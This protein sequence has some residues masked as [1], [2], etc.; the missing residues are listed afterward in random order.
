MLDRKTLLKNLSLGFL[1]LLIFIIADEIFGLTVGLLVAIAFGLAETIFVYLREKRID[2]FILF[3]TGL[4]VVLGLVSILLQNDLFFKLKPG[5][6]EIILIVLLGLTAF[7]KNPVL[8]RMTGRYMKGM[9]FSGEQIDQMRKMMRRMVYLFTAHTILIFYSAYYLS[10]EAWGFISGGLLYILMGGI[11]LVEFIRAR[12]Q[13]RKIIQQMQKE[14]WFDIVTPK[15]EIIGKAP[16]SAVHGNPDLLHP[17][18]HVHIVNSKGE[19]FLQKRAATKDLYPGYWDTAIGGHVSSGE[20]INHALNRE[21]EEELGISMVQFQPLFRYV[22][23]NPHESELVHGFLLRD[24]GP[25]YINREEISRGRFWKL[26]EIEKK[27]GN[28]VFT[29][30]FEHDFDLLKK[31]VFNSSPAPEKR[32]KSGR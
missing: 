3:D 24:D 28:N 8:I 21:A 16:R 2:R 5:L 13:R 15:G 26:N 1:P 27:L 23:K 4:I 10:T 29:P 17:V 18:V 31:Y 7:S 32:K 30:N 25:F 14:E 9:E 19:L 6:I 12:L 22:M 20:S 11:F